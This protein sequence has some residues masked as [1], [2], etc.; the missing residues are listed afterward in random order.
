MLTTLGFGVWVARA[1]LLWWV[2]TL[3]GRFLNGD[4][5]VVVK[6]VGVVARGSEAPPAA[7]CNGQP[8]GGGGDEGVV[9]NTAEDD[10]DRERRLWRI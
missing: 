2:S 6:V 3:K 1:G 8:V 5:P 7:N 4:R 9:M 10:E